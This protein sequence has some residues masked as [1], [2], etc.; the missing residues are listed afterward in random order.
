M[1]VVAVGVES[2]EQRVR[3][4]F[5]AEVEERRLYAVGRLLEGAVVEVD[6]LADEGEAHGGGHRAPRI[7]PP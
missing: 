5:G 6:A 2:G 1:A 7:W 4:A 3:R